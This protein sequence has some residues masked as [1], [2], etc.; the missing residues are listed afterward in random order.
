MLIAITL[1]MDASIDQSWDILQIA[2]SALD[3]RPR[4]MV[5]SDD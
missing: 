1:S 4:P 2:N 3:D 5:F